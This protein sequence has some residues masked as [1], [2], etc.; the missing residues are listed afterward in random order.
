M[1]VRNHLVKIGLRNLSSTQKLDKGRNHVAMLTDNANYP[2]LQTGLPEISTA[3]DKLEESILEVQF[4]GGKIAYNRKNVHEMELDELVTYLGNQVQVLSFGDQ[5]K[6]LSAGF[7]VRRAGSPIS[8]LDAPQGLR[9]S[10]SPFKGTIELRWNPVYGTKVYETFMTAGD[11][12][13]E[14]G[15][16]SVGV[17]TRCSRN[18]RNLVTGKTYSFRVSAIGASAQSAFSSVAHSIAA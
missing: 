16:V 10:I 6:I 2:T 1:N 5:S 8:T 9:A 12:N 11:P 17:S 14:A 7:E 13:W 15:W 18:V 4:N 3:C